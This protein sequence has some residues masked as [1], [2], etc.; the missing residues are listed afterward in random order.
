MTALVVVFVY[1]WTNTAQL[2]EIQ[3][4]CEVEDNTYVNVE[5]IDCLDENLPY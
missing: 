3:K 5:Y 4:M 1:Y 2:R